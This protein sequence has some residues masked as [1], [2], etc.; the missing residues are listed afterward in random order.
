MKEAFAEVCGMDYT[1]EQMQSIFDNIDI[2]HTGH[3]SY[4]DFIT[5]ASHRTDLINAKN[6][7]KTFDA[8]DREGNGYITVEEMRHIFQ[9]HNMEHDVWLEVLK[10]IGITHDDKISFDTFNSMMENLRWR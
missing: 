10:R 8:F 4:D 6:L 9:H 2:E 5:L 7:H 1:A 3:I